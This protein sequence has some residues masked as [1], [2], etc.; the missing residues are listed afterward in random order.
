MTP[1][2]LMSHVFQTRKFVMTILYWK[3]G[4]LCGNNDTADLNLNSLISRE[5]VINLRRKPYFLEDDI[6][7]VAN[8]VPFVDP[9]PIYIYIYI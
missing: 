7:F 2:N 1:W 8:N 6:L 3:Q 4:L 5:H 9:G